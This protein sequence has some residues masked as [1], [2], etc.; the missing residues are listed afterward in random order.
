MGPDSWG[1]SA[2]HSFF[3]NHLKT[4][5]LACVSGTWSVWDK[6]T[7]VFDGHLMSR[8]EPYS[9]SL[10]CVAHFLIVCLSKA[11]LSCIMDEFLKPGWHTPLSQHPVT[12]Q[13]TFFGMRKKA[14]GDPSFYKSS[15]LFPVP[16]T[17][18]TAALEQS[19]GY[20]LLYPGSRMQ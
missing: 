13:S 16:S 14:L 17:P 8:T 9:V 3:P 2:W 7:F 5:L 11:A 6:R 10:H 19:C 12:T 18:R 15:S 20:R 1:L 4:H